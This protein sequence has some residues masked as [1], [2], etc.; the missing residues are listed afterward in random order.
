MYSLTFCL[1]LSLET[2]YHSVKPLFN[3]QCAVIVMD[4]CLS[5]LTTIK[6]NIEMYV[7]AISI[8]PNNN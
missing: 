2:L 3:Y 1:L 5:E 6:Y 4:F 8:A 7:G